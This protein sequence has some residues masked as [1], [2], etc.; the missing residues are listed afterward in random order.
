MRQPTAIWRGPA[1]RGIAGAVFVPAT[2][3]LRLTY[4]DG[5]TEEVGP[6]PLGE[7]GGVVLSG[8]AGQIL[9]WRE[10]GLFASLNLS[11]SNW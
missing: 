7:G 2:R 5:A 11:S 10:D 3:M 6:L 1:G 4:D 8:T 9:E